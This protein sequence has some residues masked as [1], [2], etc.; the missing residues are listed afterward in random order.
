MFA[1]DA[2][3]GVLVLRGMHDTG[4]AESAAAMFPGE[5]QLTLRSTAGL[6]LAILPVKTRLGKKR[7]MASEREWRMLA[8]QRRAALKH[9]TSS[10]L[11]LR[12]SHRHGEYG[13]GPVF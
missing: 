6:P 7:T 12:A 9:K 8:L 1:G 3:C 11:H 5:M 4:Y 10:A 13:D 2:G